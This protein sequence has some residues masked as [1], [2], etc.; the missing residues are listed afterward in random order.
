M[1]KPSKRKYL[2]AFLERTMQIQANSNQPETLEPLRLWVESRLAA[3]PKKPQPEKSIQL[4][5]DLKELSARQ[6]RNEVL[7]LRTA[8]REHLKS[9]KSSL[10]YPELYKLLPENQ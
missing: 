6:L 10:E 2:Q 8:L 1:G 4:D 3:Q 9:A 7:R 5:M